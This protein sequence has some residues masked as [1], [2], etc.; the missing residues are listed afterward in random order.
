MEGHI[1]AQGV[2]CILVLEVDYIRALVVGY[3]MVQEVAYIPVPVE[4]YIRALVGA[5][6]L[7]LVI[8]HIVVTYPL[9][10]LC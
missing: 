10:M 8:I 7:D 6:I 9:E 1:L 3:I 5:F 2:G 4:G